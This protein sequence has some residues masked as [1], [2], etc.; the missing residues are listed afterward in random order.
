M[1]ASRYVAALMVFMVASSIPSI[2]VAQEI[3]LAT[4]S[5]ERKQDLGKDESQELKL[6]D[7]R[8]STQEFTVKRF[9][10]QWHPIG[11][12]MKREPRATRA[13]EGYLFKYSF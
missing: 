1:N 9:P 4:P 5:A 7:L 10:E 8:E 2:G 12:E 3:A 13:Q 6:G 11:E